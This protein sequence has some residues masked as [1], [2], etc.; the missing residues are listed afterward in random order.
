MQ[1]FFV[2]AENPDDVED[3]QNF[4]KIE[5]NLDRDYQKDR[6]SMGMILEE[7][8]G[9]FFSLV[10]GPF[11]KKFLQLEHKLLKKNYMNLENLIASMLDSGDNM[12][13]KK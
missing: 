2:K 11:S 7:N 1:S 4:S 5:T 6:V 12:K 13:M 10:K 8:K 3:D 9:V